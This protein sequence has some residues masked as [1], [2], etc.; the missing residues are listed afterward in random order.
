M[1]NLIKLNSRKLEKDEIKSKKWSFEAA[2]F[3]NRLLIRKPE[4]RLGSKG[5]SELKEHP[6]FEGFLW[7][8]LYYKTLIAPL[9]QI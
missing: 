2:D 4:I 5:I 7:N 6:W 3:I 9:S 8:E 1:P